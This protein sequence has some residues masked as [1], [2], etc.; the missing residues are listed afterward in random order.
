[1]LIAAEEFPLSIQQTEHYYD[2]RSSGTQK[3]FPKWEN[4]RV[5]EDSLHFP[6]RGVSEVGCAPLNC[7]KK[8]EFSDTDRANSYILLA[9]F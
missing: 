3:H 2:H 5:S 4:R 7:Q 6:K 8:I 9:I 1:M